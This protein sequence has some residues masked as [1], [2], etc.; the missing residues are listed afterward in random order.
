MTIE[1]YPFATTLE[2]GPVASLRCAPKREQNSMLA[3]ENG[4]ALK[5]LN[6]NTRGYSSTLTYERPTGQGGQISHGISDYTDGTKIKVTYINVDS[7]AM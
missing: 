4:T 3:I 6:C 1:E 7:P 2:G 5:E